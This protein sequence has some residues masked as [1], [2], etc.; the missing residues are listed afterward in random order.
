MAKKNN[1]IIKELKRR[2]LEA[3]RVLSAEGVL[4]GSGHLSAKIPGTETFLINPRYAGVLATPDDLCV[5]DFSAKRVAGTEPIPLET[6]IHSIIYKSRADIGSVLHCHPRF[7]ILVGLQDS[8][9]V[10]FNRDARMFAEGVPVFP[11]SAGI[12]SD[13]LAEQM[14]EAMG[15]HYAV[16]LKGHGIVVAEQTIE[17]NAVSAIRLERA[18]RDQILLSSFSRPQPLNDGAR[19]R[20]RSRMDH[21]YRIWPYLLYQHG[22]KSKKDARK[23]T[24][25]MLK[26]IWPDEIKL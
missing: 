14:L 17:G 10:P 26:Q 20:I 18:A 19:G 5:V 8:S 1:K 16:F 4:D 15:D 24:R 12:N 11:N 7:S 2:L 3:I 22:I 9:L 21:P 23:L 25:S 13:K 6:V